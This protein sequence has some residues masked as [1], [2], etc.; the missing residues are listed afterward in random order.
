MKD[1]AT[2]H[3]EGTHPRRRCVICGDVIKDKH[4]HDAHPI[5]AGRCCDVC[6]YTVVVPSRIALSKKK[7]EP[8]D[9]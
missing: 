1:D 5:A 6:N 7:E 2:R 9:T 8:R 3:P 4:G